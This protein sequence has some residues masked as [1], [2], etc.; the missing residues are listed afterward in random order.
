MWPKYGVFHAFPPRLTPLN[1]LRRWPL[2]G[3]TAALA[4][5]VVLALPQALPVLRCRRRLLI[6]FCSRVLTFEA[7]E[8]YIP[9][10]GTPPPR[11][12]GASSKHFTDI[13]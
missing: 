12:D 4:P 2:P 10:F 1:C 9:S 5:A 7:V 8:D 6:W 3:S 11:C 13:R